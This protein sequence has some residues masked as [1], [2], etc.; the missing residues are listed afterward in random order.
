MRFYAVLTKTLLHYLMILLWTTSLSYFG[1]EI[2]DTSFKM[3]TI[4]ML[5]N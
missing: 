5:F 3:Y 2:H 1:M 4:I